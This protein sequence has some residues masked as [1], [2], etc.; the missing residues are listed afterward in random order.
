VAEA[1]SGGEELVQVER[2]EAHAIVRMMCFTTTGHRDAV[3]E[4]LSR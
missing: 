4:L 1:L 3:A 2:G